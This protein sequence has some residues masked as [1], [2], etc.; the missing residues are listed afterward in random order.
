MDDLYNTGLNGRETMHPCST[1]CHHNSNEHL[2][3]GVQSME[4]MNFSPSVNLVIIL[5]DWLLKSSRTCG[6]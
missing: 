2:S 3:L 4:R 6:S 5:H 1:K